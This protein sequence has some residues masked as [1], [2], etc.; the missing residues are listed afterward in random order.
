M[1]TISPFDRR[2]LDAYLACRAAEHHGHAQAICAHMGLR[3]TADNLARV[4][5]SIDRLTTAARALHREQ[6]HP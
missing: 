4:L 3:I 6:T 2:V 1:L 5:R